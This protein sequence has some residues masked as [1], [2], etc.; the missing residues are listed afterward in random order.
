[1][2]VGIDPEDYVIGDDAT[3]EDADLDQDAIYLRDGTRLTERRAE[4]VAERTLA[5]IRHR[6]LVPGRKSLTGGSTHSPRVQFR[7]PDSL[8]ERAEQ[9]AAA[10]GKSLSALAREALEHYLEAS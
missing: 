6:N 5:E 10:E 4:Q 2:T 7:V 1:V 9:R 8:R 3:I